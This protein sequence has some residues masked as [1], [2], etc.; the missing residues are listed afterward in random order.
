NSQLHNDHNDIN[1]ADQAINVTNVTNVANVANVDVDVVAKIESTEEKKK[2]AE[3]TIL[4]H[5]EWSDR[6]LD[7]EGVHV[8][9]GDPFYGSAKPDYFRDLLKACKIDKE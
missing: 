4:N 5:L 8:S 3:L 9:T 1:I 6:Y 7:L 2:Y